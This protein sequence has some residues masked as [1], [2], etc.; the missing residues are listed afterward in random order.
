VVNNAIV[1]NWTPAAE[2]DM[3]PPV[4]GHCSDNWIGPARRGSSTT[5][6]RD[7]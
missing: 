2:P 1:R 7:V 3:T 4:V 6:V 5:S